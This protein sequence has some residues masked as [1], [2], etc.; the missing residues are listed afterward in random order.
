MLERVKTI[1]TSSKGYQRLEYVRWADDL[2]ILIDGY[3]EWDGLA[4][5]AYE[6]LREELTKLDVTLNLEKTRQVNLRKN[7]TFSFLGFVFRRIKTK[8]GK[9]GLRKT[10]KI[11]ARTKTF[12]KIKSK[13]SGKYTFATKSHSYCLMT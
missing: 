7:E 9:W 1:T 6:Q 12:R 5:K 8:Q 13:R 11:I 10:P 3:R 4:R 2:V